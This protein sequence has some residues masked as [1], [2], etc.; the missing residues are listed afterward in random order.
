MGKTS[1]VLNHY[2]RNKERFSD[3]V[4]GIFF[5]GAHVIQPEQLT[6]AS[7]VYVEAEAEN[8]DTGATGKYLDRIRDI[9]MR[10]DTGVLLAILAVENQSAVDYSM[11]FRCLQYDTMEYGRQLEDLRHKNDAEDTY[12]NWAEKVCKIKKTD[13]LVPVYTICVYY[14][15]DI[16]DGPRSLKDMM[17]FG[18]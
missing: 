10:L 3:F 1:N 15:E 17:D 13:R 9:K 18:L 14:G 11:P 5:R 7:E 16:W 6:D 8:A 2:F 12:S 4:N